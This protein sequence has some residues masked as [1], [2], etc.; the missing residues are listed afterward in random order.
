MKFKELNLPN[1]LSILRILMALIIIV[2]LLFPFHNVGLEFPKYLV[3]GTYIDSKYLIAG[4]LFVLASV[5][6]FLDGNIARKRNLV[7]DFGK[8]VDAIADKVLVNSV[9]IILSAQGFIPP[10]IVVIVIVRDSIVNAIKMVAGG[11]GNVVAASN[12]GKIKTAA[13][14]AGITLTLFYNLPFQL[15]NLPVADFLLAFAAVMAFISGI[16]YF[17]AN[18]KHL[19][20]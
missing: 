9:L 10:V 5:T 1:K 8:T 12:L 2:I 15:I 17:K 19:K 13:L 4:V 16:D 20:Q 3:S 11:K 18:K 6:D 14:M 7:T